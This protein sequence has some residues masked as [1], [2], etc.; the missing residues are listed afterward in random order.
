MSL[1]MVQMELQSG[2]KVDMSREMICGMK[3]LCGKN[4]TMNSEAAVR[5]ALR[6][7]HNCLDI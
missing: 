7:V 6:L 3:V 1:S 4:V 2:L 5:I